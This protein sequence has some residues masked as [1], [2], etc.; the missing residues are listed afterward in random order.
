MEHKRQIVM[1]QLLRGRVDGYRWCG[2][3]GGSEW[4]EREELDGMRGDRGLV[5]LYKLA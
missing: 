5:E 4:M 3:G 1:E 2:L